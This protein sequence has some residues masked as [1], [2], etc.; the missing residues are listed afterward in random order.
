[1][2]A[3][4]KAKSGAAPR[5]TRTRLTEDRIAE[6]LDIAAEV[7]IVEGFAAASTNRIASLASASKAT[8][9]SRFPTK[10]DLFLAVI[11]RRIT[12]IFEQVARFP[13]GESMRG[14]MTQFAK[15]VLTVAFSPEQIALIRM[16]SMES[17]KYPEL[18]QRFYTLGPKRAEDSLAAYLV[19]R[20]KRGELVDEDP[21]TMARNFMN[22]L[23]GSPV[24]WFVLGF[25]PV[26]LT[27]GALD[28]HVDDVLKLFMRAYKG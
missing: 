14:C 27:A 22:L 13:D 7:F 4:G 18:A 1:M 5:A 3:A 15:G 17:G 20:T 28:K 8:F 2:R 12:R 16:I 11:E 24:R 6:L 10:Q 19:G 25:D 26:P 9:Y 21:L 23:T